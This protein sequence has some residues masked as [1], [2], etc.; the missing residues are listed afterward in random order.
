MART[1]ASLEYCILVNDYCLRFGG[2]D[3]EGQQERL[4]VMGVGVMDC[5]DIAESKRD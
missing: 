2:T 1:R 5:Y 4:W 3:D